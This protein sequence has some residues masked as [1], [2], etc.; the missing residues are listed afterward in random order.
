[1]QV[2]LQGSDT[3]RCGPCFLQ[4]YFLMTL[5]VQRLLCSLPRTSPSPLLFA[6]VTEP[7]APLS[8]WVSHCWSQLS[9]IQPTP[10]TVLPAPPTPT[11]SWFAA[12]LRGGF[13]Q[14][15]RV[16]LNKCMLERVPIFSASPETGTDLLSHRGKAVPTLKRVSSATFLWCV[17]ASGPTG[18]AGSLVAGQLREHR[19]E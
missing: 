16:W 4:I 14:S 9:F 1:M 5:K 8:Y 10:A 7:L 17:C 18:C 11:D 6:S 13:G 2:T 19:R 12:A 3:E 15:S